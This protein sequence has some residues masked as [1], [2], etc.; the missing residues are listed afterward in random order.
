LRPRERRISA[1]TST[2]PGIVAQY[3][4]DSAHR[5]TDIQDD[6]GN[7]IHPNQC[8]TDPSGD[9]PSWQPL[10]P[11]EFG[12]EGD[13]LF[14]PFP[15]TPFNPYSNHSPVR[16][17]FFTPSSVFPWIQAHEPIKSRREALGLSDTQVAEKSGL[18]IYEP[19]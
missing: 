6:L 7:T 9:A 16:S 17:P 4:Y 18:S 13:P 8:P 5:L 11:E 2:T 12:I 19:V 1:A 15:Y 10:D 3:T 14:S